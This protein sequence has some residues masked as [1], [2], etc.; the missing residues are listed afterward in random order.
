M[1]ILVTGDDGIFAEGLWT[2][3]RE[4]KR[5]FDVIVVA[6]DRK[7]NAVG[8]ATTV[9]RPIRAH[10]VK[11]EPEVETWAVEGTPCDSIFLAVHKLAKGRIDLVLSG[12]NEGSNQDGDVVNS[13]TVAAAFTAYLCGLP[14]VAI[15][16]DLGNNQYW[17]TA[18]K[19]G[20][21]LAKYVNS[22]VLL[23]NICL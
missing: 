13:G 8:T 23:P 4:L 2:L 5:S 3:V 16:Q 15:S 22:G 20:L 10:K 1:T 9:D 7:Q 19:L 12:I 14:A 21:L 11:L 18:A 6:A 17:G